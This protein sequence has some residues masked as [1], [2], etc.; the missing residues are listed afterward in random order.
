MEHLRKWFDDLLAEPSIVWKHTRGAR[1]ECH[2]YVSPRIWYAAV[3]IKI[4]PNDKFEIEDVSEPKIVNK[5]IDGLRWRDQIVFGVLDV[6]LTQSVAPIRNF[7]L[8]ILGVDFNEIESNPMAFR[9]AARDAALKIL[10][11]HNSA[12]E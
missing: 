9:L 11:L 10:N 5:H 1:G 12:L 7:K 4:S 8:T 6:M 3:E 2:K